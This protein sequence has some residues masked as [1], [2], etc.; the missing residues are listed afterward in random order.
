MTTPGYTVATAE[1]ATDW[2]AAYPG[3]GQM[4]SYRDAT[5]SE[6]VAITWRSM[7]PGT[8]GRGS[9]GHR[10]PGQEEIYLVIGG[11]VTFKVGDDTFEAEPLTA[12]RV[13]GESFRSVHND[14]ADEATLVIV[15]IRDPEATTENQPDFW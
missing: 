13:G 12:V 2:M 3:F 8:G 14:G 15:S 4:L 5:A 11:K 6:Q 9:Y 10:H 7:P 1:Q